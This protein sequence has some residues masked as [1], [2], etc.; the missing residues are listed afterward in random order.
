MNVPLNF[1]TIVADSCRYDTY[2]MANTPTLDKYFDVV[3]GEAQATFTF[4]AHAAMMQGFYPSTKDNRPLYNRFVRTPFQW[5]YATLRDSL[6]TVPKNGR[7][8]PES[9]SKLGWRTVCIGGV[10]WFRKPSQLECGFD[11]FAYVSN[12]NRA[13]SEFVTKVDREPFYGVLNFGVTHRPYLCPDMPTRLKARQSPRS[14]VGHGSAY[15]YLLHSRQAYCMGWLDRQL[16][17]LL[18]WIADLKL[19]T[20][21]CFCADHGECF[22]EDGC[23]G[24]AFYHKHVMSVPLAWSAF[25][26]GNGQPVDEALFREFD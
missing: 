11:H 8:I 10:G 25:D 14:G 13:I 18:S 26:K 19:T 6:I 15:D 21:V 20:I 7:T 16:D 9:L 1:L 2:R 4:P 22:G 24:H 23:F 12:A 17:V 3:E 5:H